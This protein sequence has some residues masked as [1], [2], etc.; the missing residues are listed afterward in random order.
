MRNPMYSNYHYNPGSYGHSNQ[1]EDS[2]DKLKR[3]YNIDYGLGP[4]YDEVI[5]YIKSN[6][7]RESS[8]KTGQSSTVNDHQAHGMEEY[9]KS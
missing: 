5:L 7:N 1:Y 8:K 9:T 4:T 3:E 2:L 6:I